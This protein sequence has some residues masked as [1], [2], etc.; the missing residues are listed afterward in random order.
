MNIGGGIKVIKGPCVVRRDWTVLLDC[1]HP[2]FEAVR[3][4]LPAFAELAKSPP[5]YQTYRITP[6]SLWNAAALGASPDEIIESLEQ[7]SRR[8]LPS[9]L[10]E[11]IKL[12]MSRYGRLTLHAMDESER[13]LLRS[14]SEELLNEPEMVRSPRPAASAEQGRWKWP[15]AHPAGD[16]EAGARPNRISGAGPRW[17]S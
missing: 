6:L 12:L 3:D 15:E 14:D 16:A 7:W 11:E 9:G 2:E 8:V 10:A 17:L 4:R 5:L 13:L 1:G